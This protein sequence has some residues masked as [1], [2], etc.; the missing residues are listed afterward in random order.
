MLE[1]KKTLVSMM[2]KDP[3]VSVMTTDR[4]RGCRRAFKVPELYREN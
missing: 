3:V 4:E 2:S 1:L